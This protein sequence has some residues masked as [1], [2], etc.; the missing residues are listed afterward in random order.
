MFQN[1]KIPVYVIEEQK[2]ITTKKVSSKWD[3]WFSSYGPLKY[4]PL[5]AGALYPLKQICNLLLILK[6]KS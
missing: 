2:W 5:L 6:V 4:W 1:L 3:Q